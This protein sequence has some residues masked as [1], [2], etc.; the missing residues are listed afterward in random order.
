MTLEKQSDPVVFSDGSEHFG[1]RFLKL[2]QFCAGIATVFP[3]ASPVESDFSV[4]KWEGDEMRSSLTDFSLEGVMQCKHFKQPQ[5][6]KHRVSL[7]GYRLKRIF[8]VGKCFCLFC[9]LYLRFCFFVFFA[10]HFCQPLR[11]FAISGVL[12]PV[13]FLL[14][15][16]PRVV[17]RLQ[18][19]LIS[20]R[21]LRGNW[22]PKPAHFRCTMQ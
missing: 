19:A 13:Q 5:S 21:Q 11:F 18:P 7:L 1:Q 3:G 6:M 17:A 12:L 9:V 8:G 2:R 14:L 15:S 22:A 20:L 16:V 4:L 10:A